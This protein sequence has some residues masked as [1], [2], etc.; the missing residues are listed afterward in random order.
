MEDV[1]EAFFVYWYVVE[2]LIK[3]VVHR[4]YFFTN[5][6]GPWN[7][8]DLLVVLWSGLDWLLQGMS[9]G[10]AVDIRFVRVCR[11]LRVSKILRIFRAFRFLFELRLMV[12]CVLGSLVPLMWAII[13]LLLV[14]MM[15]SLV[16]V[17]CMIDYQREH[18]DMPVD[19]VLEI[20]RY[21]GSVMMTMI[22]LFQCTTGG[23]DWAP[24]YQLVSEAGSLYSFLFL[25]FITFFVFAFFNIVTSIFVDK[26]MNLA[27]HDIEFTR[28]ERTQEEMEKARDL[29]QMIQHFDQDGSGT[30]SRSEL[31]EISKD[32]RIR[33]RFEMY[34][35]N[36][37]DADH[38]FTTVSD[39]VGVQELDID[40][41]VAGWLKMKGYATSI[42]QQA[43][44]LQMYRLTD[45]VNCIAAGL[46]TDTS[47]HPIHEL[48]KELTSRRLSTSLQPQS[49]SSILATAEQGQAASP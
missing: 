7:I 17:E 37:K 5:N 32:Q 49:P 38:L 22:I 18:P 46:N 13:L 12:S 39:L 42:D 44:I 33:D 48:K 19:R 20:D 29:R 41:F 31:V 2:V 14:L 23:E 35:L 34:E 21:F 9:V 27:Q 40:T 36:I 1:A 3:L 47:Q 10:Q 30:I 43:I 16:F 4:M 26:A 11:V 15:F 6:D 45:T 8:F 25:F 28:L 24:I